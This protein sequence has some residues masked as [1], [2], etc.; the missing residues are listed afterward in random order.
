MDQRGKQVGKCINDTDEDGEALNL[1]LNGLL[2][3]E[4]LGER[5]PKSQ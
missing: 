5:L 4:Y 2:D 1:Y 3:K